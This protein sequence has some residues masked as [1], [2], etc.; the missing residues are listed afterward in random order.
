M[1][2]LPQAVHE[3]DDHWSALYET[4]SGKD[5]SFSIFSLGT[6]D[7]SSEIF[8]VRIPYLLSFLSTNTFD[9]A[10]KGINN[11]QAEYT[12]MY[13]AAESSLLTCPTDGAF[14]PII[15]AN[16]WSFRSMIG[17]GKIAPTGA[18]VGV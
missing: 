14:T 5:A 10:V 6:P 13:Y 4:A 1:A 15:W 11:L 2:P 18:A 16:Y 9:G 17:L 8:S 7:G 12:E 3:R